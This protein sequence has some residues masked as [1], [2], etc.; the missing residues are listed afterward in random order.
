MGFLALGFNG[1]PQVQ[2]SLNAVAPKNE[3]KLVHVRRSL[4]SSCQFRNNSS[5]C[6]SPQTGV[7]QFSRNQVF[8]STPNYA[9]KQCD[10][11]L[12]HFR[13]MPTTTCRKSVSSKFNK[14][15]AHNNRSKVERDR[16][17]GSSR[18]NCGSMRWVWPQTL[19]QRV[20]HSHASSSHDNS[21]NSESPQEE[22]EEEDDHE[23]HKIYRHS[24]WDQPYN[25]PPLNTHHPESVVEYDDEVSSSQPKTIFMKHYICS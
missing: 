10:Y 25:I 12:K 23:Y 13:A 4:N 15:G 14:L 2:F 16:K 9:S 7:L 19:M 21:S 11:G 24:H 5:Y 17:N 1:P 6:S 3:F 18:Q 20:I 22:E 8:S